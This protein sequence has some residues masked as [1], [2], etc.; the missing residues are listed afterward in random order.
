MSY[1]TVESNQIIHREKIN[2]LLIKY[3]YKKVPETE[4]IDILEWS[5]S[6]KQFIANSLK[7]AKINKVELEG[8]SVANVWLDD[9]QRSLA[10]GRSGKNISLASKLIGVDIN[11]V[12]LDSDITD[13]G[14]IE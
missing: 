14:Q 11:L 7:P 5:E 6:A 2:K 3:I 13:I 9:D 12:Q 4:K 1:S 8:D 10:I